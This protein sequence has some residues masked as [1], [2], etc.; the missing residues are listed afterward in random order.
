MMGNFAL[1]EEEWQTALRLHREVGNGGGAAFVLHHL[2]RLRRREGRLSEAMDLLVEALGA[3]RRLD[4]D[5]MAA[6]CIAA[7][8][9]LAL[10]RGQLDQAATLLSAAQH[11][12]AER[13]PFL[14]PADI[15]EYDRDIAA[16]RAQLGD[17]TFAVAWTAGQALDLAQACEWALAL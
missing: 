15:A 10:E 1:A 16:C 12:F 6:R 7:I 4:K 9:G 13:P 5:D 8:G 17:E 3:F 2:A 14:A 11:Y